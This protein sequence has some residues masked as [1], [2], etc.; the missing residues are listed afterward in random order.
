TTNGT[1]ATRV[2]GFRSIE[3]SLRMMRSRNGGR[4]TLGAFAF[5]ALARALAWPAFFGRPGAPLG[6]EIGLVFGAERAGRCS[7]AGLRR[8]GAS[9][10]RRPFRGFRRRSSFPRAGAERLT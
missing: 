6:R 9:G 1:L 8:D 10:A 4:M 3:A 5:R 7:R 2:R